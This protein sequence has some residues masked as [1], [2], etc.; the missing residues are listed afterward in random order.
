MDLEAFIWLIFLLMNMG[1]IAL[2]FYQIISLSDLESDHLNPYKAS[3]RINSVVIPEYLLHGAWCILFLLTGHWVFFLLNLL[4]VYLNVTKFMKRQHLI[5]VT[6]AFAVLSAEQKLRNV[7]MIFYLVLLA[8]VMIRLIFAINNH[9]ADE[10]EA[11]NF[12]GLF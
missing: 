2:N 3:S 7:K 4:P 1:L 10:G 11:L 5:D 12:Y 6:E 9:Y 8:I